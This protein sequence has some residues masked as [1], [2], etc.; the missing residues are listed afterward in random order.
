MITAAARVIHASHC[1]GV[2]LTPRKAGGF[3]DRNAQSLVAAEDTGEVR[4]HLRQRNGERERCAGEVRAAQPRARDADDC[5]G[6]SGG[7]DRREHHED[8]RQVVV[9]REEHRR[10]VRADHH[11]RAVSER[12]L[13]VDAGE[14]RQAR[15]GDR[16]DRHLGD[17]VVGEGIEHERGEQEQ[18]DRQ[19]QKEQPVS[20]ERRAAESSAHTWRCLPK[21]EQS[22]RPEHE[23]HD[24]DHK[25]T[26]WSEVG[27]DISA[28][29]AQRQSDTDCT[30][31]RTDRALES[32]DDGARETEHEDLIHVARI[33]VHRRCGEHPRECSEQRRQA[34]PRVSILPTRMPRMR[35]ISGLNAAARMRNPSVVR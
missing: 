21:R 2:K 30:C 1:S 11:Q 10:R 3:G 33:E 17:V 7:Q 24:Q 26:E 29:I 22:L 4:R 5:A 14:H 23:H 32:A 9:P 16:V 31:D 19:L 13:S 8:E 34:H 25:S 15:C 18:H 28:D 12:H 20:H 27:A 6:D 35:A